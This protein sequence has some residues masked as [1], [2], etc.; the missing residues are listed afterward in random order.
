MTEIIHTLFPF[1]IRERSHTATSLANLLNSR[2]CVSNSVDHLL[3]ISSIVFPRNMEGGGTETG[4]EDPG[5]VE[6][7]AGCGFSPVVGAK[8]IRPPKLLR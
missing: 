5:A 7:E 4:R 6:V 8:Y 3:T 2:T 1:S